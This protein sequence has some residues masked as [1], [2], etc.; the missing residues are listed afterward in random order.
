MNQ[1]IP[2]RRLRL[3]WL[4]L[5][6]ILLP[7]L[8]GCG[9]HLRGS[10]ADTAVGRLP[11]AVSPIYIQGVAPGD[12]LYQALTLSLR[13]AGATVTSD[14][15]GAASRLLIDERRSQRKVLSVDSRGKVLE[16]QLEE[17]L[18]FRLERDGQ[19]A[20]QPQRIDVVQT[21]L[22]ADVLVLGKSEEERELRSDMYR[23]IAD[24]L[25]RRLVAQLR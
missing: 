20:V 9:F 8:A 2:Y 6:L 12:R 19:E 1:A 25:A 21:Y 5:L 23:R 14:P 17:G 15:A 18:R 24:Q 16:Y 3:P 4:L 22:S 13:A 10:A 11:E 7:L